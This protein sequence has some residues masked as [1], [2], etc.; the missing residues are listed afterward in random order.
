MALELLLK[1]GSLSSEIASIGLSQRG[2]EISAAASTDWTLQSPYD[3]ST[4]AMFHA[5]IVDGDILA[6]SRDLFDAGFYGQAV[7]EACKA[8]DKIVLAKSGRTSGSGTA[9]MESVFSP[10]KPALQFSD[11][12]TR[13]QQDQQQGYH[14]MLAGIMLGV[15]NPLAHEHNWIDDPNEALECILFIQHLVGKVKLSF[16]AAKPP[17]PPAPT[18]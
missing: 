8:L 6:V 16:P 14:R 4:D 18:S 10:T 11:L 17:T 5:L 3:K 9:L 1:V 12:S 13:S 15:R 7:E 2:V